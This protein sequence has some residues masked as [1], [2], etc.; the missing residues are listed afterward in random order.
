MEQFRE[1]VLGISE[2]AFQR[3]M[4]FIDWEEAQWMQ[5]VGFEYDESHDEIR[6]MF[7]TSRYGLKFDLTMK[8]FKTLYFGEDGIVHLEFNEDYNFF[9]TLKYGT[10][11]RH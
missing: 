7:K 9:K 6:L 8:A 3:M 1:Y 5:Y 11:D 2:P 10:V 4:S